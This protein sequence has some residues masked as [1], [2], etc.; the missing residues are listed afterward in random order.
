[1]FKNLNRQMDRQWTGFGVP[2]DKSGALMTWKTIVSF[3]EDI[4]P[5]LKTRAYSPLAKRWL[6]LVHG[7]GFVTSDIDGLYN[8]GNSAN[9]AIALGFVSDASLIIAESIEFAG[10]RW[11][12]DKKHSKDNNERFEGLTDLWK[13]LDMRD[14]E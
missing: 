3:R 5:S 11:S 9:E 2:R 6:D 7:N 4:P 12:E 10:L 14:A 13:A 8:A 1:M